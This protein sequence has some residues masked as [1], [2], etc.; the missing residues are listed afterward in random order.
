MADMAPGDR[1][2]EGTA[3]VGT[4]D[5]LG[6]LAVLGEP[7]RRALYRYV[8]GSAREVSRA[9]AADAV[10]VPAHTAKFH[11]D[12]LES[13][14]LLASSYRR[15][16]GRGGPGAGRPTKW[17]RRSEEELTV[18]LPE[19]RYELVGEVMAAAIDAAAGSGLDLSAPLQEAA[20]RTGREVGAG[21]GDAEGALAAVGYE[22]HADGD[23]TIL[24]NC[25]FHR[26]AESHTE[27]VCGI[28]LAFVDGILDAASDGAGLQARLEPCPGRCC[29]VLG[30][31]GPQGSG[32]CGH[33]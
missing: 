5:R 30:P 3:E 6:R 31:R 12:R 17:Y 20:R 14:G 9:E 18:S 25:P 24:V 8:A 23:D 26:L 4:H 11:L 16:P 29:V 13:E 22:P 28:N 7:V 10:G 33:C 2:P 15:P 32:T 19:R 1:S 27:L 21:V